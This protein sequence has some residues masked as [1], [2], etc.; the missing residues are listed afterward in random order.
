MTQPKALSTTAILLSAAAMLIQACGPSIRRTHQSD[1]AFERC[2]DMDYRPGS[3][4]AE[5]ETCWSSWLERYIYNQPPD[6]V[7][8]AHL[9]LKEL[10]NG[11]SVPGPPGEPGTFDERPSKEPPPETGEPAT[12]EEKVVVTTETPPEKSTCETNCRALFETCNGECRTDAG[13]D[14]TCNGACEK[15]LAK[16]FE[17][18]TK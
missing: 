9:R 1:N 16:C 7:G 11:I 8:Y 10:A 18:C 4:P 15:S 12:P 5:K 6:K 14:D 2:F 17:L 13:V 3:E